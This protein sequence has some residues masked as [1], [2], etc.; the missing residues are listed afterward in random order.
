M[1][2]EHAANLGGLIARV[3]ADQVSIPAY[4]GDPVSVDELTG[5][6]SQDKRDAGK[7]ERRSLFHA[8]NMEA[9]A[10]RA[11][12]DLKADYNRNNLDNFHLGGGEY[13]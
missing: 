8:L 11:A 4:I 10:R 5:A 2:T 12:Q 6:N 1:Q 3:T 7:I 13:R 9:I